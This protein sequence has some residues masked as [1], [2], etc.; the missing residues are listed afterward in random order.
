MGGDGSAANAA[1]HT[2]LG[3]AGAAAQSA[4]CAAGGVG[5]LS[6][7][8]LNKLLDSAREDATKQLSAE[9][10]QSR[11]D[12]VGSI[13]T[14]I[15]A[16]IDPSAVATV[17]TGANIEAENN[18]LSEAQKA[19][20][21]EEI[22]ACKSWTCVVTAEAKWVAIDTGQDVSFYTGVV[23]GVPAGA[24]DLALGILQV[25]AS[26][27]ETYAALKSLFE[28]GDVLEKV[29]AAIKQSYIE[30]ITRMEAE[31]QRAGAGG[32]FNAGVEGGKLIFDL[33]LLVAGVT[34]VAKSGATL[35][36]RVAAQVERD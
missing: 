5:A 25:A 11:L 33:A 36:Q 35:T 19:Q 26:P 23:A 9:E 2:I 34:G 27:G 13:V 32:S 21:N 16:A 22:Q 6:S 14:G 30:R 17:L 20:R 31:Y 29:P 10:R 8:V 7:V 4:S 12:F 15:T 1:L 3:C 28:R 24:V 18:Y